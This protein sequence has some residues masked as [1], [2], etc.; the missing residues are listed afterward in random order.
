MCATTTATSAAAG[1]TA[2]QVARDADQRSGFKGAQCARHCG[3]AG[4]GDKSCCGIVSQN[5]SLNFGEFP[6]GCHRSG[7]YPHRGLR[8]FNFHPHITHEH[9]CG[10]LDLLRDHFD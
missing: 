6:V 7:G 8:I 5:R 9:E 3:V 10:G 1:S 4:F 2:N